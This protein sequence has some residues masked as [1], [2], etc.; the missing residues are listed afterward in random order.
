MSRAD[1]LAALKGGQATLPPVFSP[2]EAQER[3]LPKRFG[4]E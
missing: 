2:A 3:P 4:D 1:R